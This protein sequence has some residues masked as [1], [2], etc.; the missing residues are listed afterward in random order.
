VS[1]ILSAP[2]ESQ[3]RQPDQ[4]APGDTGEDT[5]R[6]GEE[7][8]QVLGE[9]EGEKEEEHPDQQHISEGGEI[10]VPASAHGADQVTG[11]VDRQGT[12]PELTGEKDADQE[13]REGGG[14]KSS[15][16]REK[17]PPPS[18]LWATDDETRNDNKQNEDDDAPLSPAHKASHS[19]RH[20]ITVEE[21]DTPETE[22]K[23]VP[24][25]DTIRV[26]D[27]SNLQEVHRSLE[28]QEIE[29]QQKVSGNM[30][31][32]TTSESEGEFE[33]DEEVGLEGTETSGSGRHGERKKRR[34]VKQSKS[35][36][37]MRLRS[38]S[39]SSFESSDSTAGASHLL[40]STGVLSHQNEVENPLAKHLIDQL[41][42]LV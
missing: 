30:R 6:E 22:N 37:T 3:Q 2:A 27:L 40:Q 29:A 10:D 14:E 32:Y 9:E 31:F 39:T 41:K 11:R 1:E 23:S 21:P 17:I 24:N 42:K 35:N 16:K 38:S 34:K 33:D 28:S 15:A 20:V 5:E 18:P 13:D 19:H 25:D 12:E 26:V 36:I 4:T 7:N 8:R